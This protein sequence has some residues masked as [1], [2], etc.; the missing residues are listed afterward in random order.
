[1]RSALTLLS[2]TVIVLA[3]TVV[4]NRLPFGALSDGGPGPDLAVA[5]IVAIALTTSPS[6]AA[7]WGFGMGLALDVLPPADHAIGRY[8]LVLCLAGY[9][10]ALVH[11]NTGAPGAVAGR[12]SRWFAVGVVLVTS[13]GVGLA[14]AGLG[15]FVGDPGTGLADIAVTTV[16]G[17]ALTLLVSPLVTLPLLWLRELM[18]D[19]EFATVQGPMSP[20]GW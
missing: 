13:A 6:A 11:R 10:V 8:T 3:Q 5:A 18:V 14:Y 7:G 2:V 20:R 19:H 16:V 17:S 9:L 12:T 4:V 15:L 1:M